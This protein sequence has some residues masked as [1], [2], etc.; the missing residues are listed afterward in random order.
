MEVVII[1]IIDGFVI[2]CFGFSTIIVKRLRNSEDQEKV[3]VAVVPNRPHCDCPEVERLY[4]NSFET[5]EIAGFLKRYIGFQ[6]E[7]WEQLNE[8]TKNQA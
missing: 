4:Y 2:A 5:K 7:R 1:P 8:E 6:L 3:E